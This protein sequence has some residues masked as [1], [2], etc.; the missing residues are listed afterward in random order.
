MSSVGTLLVLFHFVDS[1]VLG[2]KERIML[3]SVLTSSTSAA[4]FKTL[5][6]RSAVSLQDALAV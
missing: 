5:R 1:T 2:K 3:V 6:I 4:A